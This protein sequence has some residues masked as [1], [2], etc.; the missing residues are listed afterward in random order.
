MLSSEEARKEHA[1]TILSMVR[2]GGYDG[3]EIDYEAIKKDDILWGY[4]ISF[5]KRLYTQ[6]SEENIRVRIVLEPGVPI[7]N[8]TL[9]AGPEYVLMCYN[10]YGYGTG[11][12]PKADKKFL[13][14]MIDK[15]KGISGKVGFAVATG[16]FDFYDGNQA[17]QI[18]EEGALKLIEENK[19]VPERD[20][21]SYSMVFTYKDREGRL[22][23]VWYADETT[24]KAW[25]DIIKESGNYG[26]SLWRM[27]GNVITD[28][29]D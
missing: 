1:D 10:L 22:H 27:G 15:M 8:L 3:I 17:E 19:A 26:I 5:I 13:L 11:P 23:E 14:K 29:Q 25:S 6:A 20:E 2:Q 12:G 7:E 18:T 21:D 9:P 4:F 16:G 28:I 24:I